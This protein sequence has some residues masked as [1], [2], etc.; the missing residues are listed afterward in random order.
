M[1]SLGCTF[2]LVI[3]LAQPLIW[4]V[5]KHYLP[6]I[7]IG[8][9]DQCLCRCPFHQDNNPSLSINIRQGLYHCHSCKAKGNVLQFVKDYEH[10]S[11]DKAKDRVNELTGIT[12]FTSIV[13]KKE[14]R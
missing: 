5:F 6:D 7:E 11:L 8:R 1:K 2:I 13:T 12:N 14:L 10:I 9:G 3:Q 4:K